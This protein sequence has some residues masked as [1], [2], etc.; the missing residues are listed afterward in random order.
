MT[1]TDQ[2]EEET[3]RRML[4]TPPKQHEPITPLGKAKKKARDNGNN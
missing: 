4:N 2:C 3:L 1:D